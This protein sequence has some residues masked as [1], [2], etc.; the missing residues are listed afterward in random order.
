MTQTSCTKIEDPN[1][2]L[3]AILWQLLQHI[4]RS[5]SQ[6]PLISPNTLQLLQ[7]VVDMVNAHMP[8]GTTRS[9][10]SL[11]A[12]G[13]HPVPSGLSFTTSSVAIAPELPRNYRGHPVLPGL[14]SIAQ[15]NLSTGGSIQE[16][17]CLNCKTPM[18]LPSE[19]QHW[20]VVT[21]GLHVGW[22]RGRQLACE[23]CESIPFAYY[24]WY[25]N[26]EQARKAFDVEYPDH[27]WVLSAPSTH[28]LP[29]G[30]GL[31]WLTP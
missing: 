10:T 19:D 31:G 24:H 27:T 15:P 23:V 7:D 17:K 28:Y 13:A 29:L 16:L 3:K 21:K 11:S 12:P 5:S 18:Q 6:D 8:Q 20:Y 9:G 14:T 2:L 25:P 22:V 1:D 4:S 30:P 26:K